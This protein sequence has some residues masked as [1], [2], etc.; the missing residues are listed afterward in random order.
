[1]D[2]WITLKSLELVASSVDVKGKKIFFLFFFFPGRGKKK[3]KKEKK[4]LPKQKLQSPT[5]GWV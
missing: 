4:R 3:Q 2:L 1:M 5:G